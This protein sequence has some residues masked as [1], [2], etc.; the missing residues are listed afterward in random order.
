M[1]SK[2]RKYPFIF[3]PFLSFHFL[4][5]KQRTSL[6][7]TVTMSCKLLKLVLC[8]C[9]RSSVCR[10]SSLCGHCLFAYSEKLC[11]PKETVDKEGRLLSSKHLVVYQVDFIYTPSMALSSYCFILCLLFWVFSLFPTSLFL[12]ISLILHWI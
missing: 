4:L 3:I 9:W 6:L 2:W 12:C 1:L 7:D 11:A 8:F 5:S 10:R